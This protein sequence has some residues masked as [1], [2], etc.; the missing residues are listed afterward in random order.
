MGA[1]A[2]HQGKAAVT[3]HTGNLAK[4][5][6]LG[7][8]VSGR[9]AGR[10]VLRKEHGLGY[11]TT[12]PGFKPQLLPPAGYVNLTESHSFLGFISPCVKWGQECL[13]QRA[14]QVL[15]YQLFQYLAV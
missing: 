4:T 13:P 9:Q 11:Q 6:W 3:C 8:Q 12:L 5:M 15:N 1:Q 7:C 14:V 2:S 10:R